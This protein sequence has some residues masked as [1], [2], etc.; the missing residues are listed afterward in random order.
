MTT[1]LPKN[2]KFQ[3]KIEAAAAKSYRSNIS[4]QASTGGYGLGDTITINIPTRS[5]LVMASSENYLKFDH[6]ITNTSGSASSYRLDSCGAHGLI[7]RLKLYHGSNLLEDIDQYGL[8]AKM[9]Y[10]LQMSTDATYGKY[11]ILSGTRNDLVVTTPASI[12][13]VNYLSATQTN[14]GEL[15]ASNL[16]TTVTSTTRNYCLNLISL[17]GSLLQNNY[18]PLFACTSAPLR[19]EITLIDS[20]TKGINCTS[21]I[22]TMR[23]DNVEFCAN[24]I[25][26]GDEAMSMVYESLNGNPLQFYCNQFRNFNTSYLAGASAYTI[27]FPI[28]AKYSSLKSILVTQRDRNT[29]ASTYFPFS[30]VAAGITD[31]S[32]K[33]GTLIMPPK[34]P[35]KLPEMFAEVLKT[36]SS[37]SDANHQPSIDLNSYTLNQSPTLAIATDPNYNAG[38]SGSFYIGLDL[39]NYSNASK[40]TLFAGYNTNTD[41]IYCQINVGIPPVAGTIRYDAFALYDAIYVFRDG[42]AYTTS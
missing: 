40:D 29:G 39:E 42:V 9:L 35:S 18:F 32:F 25:D 36:I 1:L 3:D 7:S 13:S 15:I 31:Y 28:P 22:G 5:N 16:A 10:D 37:L 11:N 19:L 6:T 30:T 27:N 14:S 23:L 38:Q 8:F 2:L 17:V 24:M 20:L 33:I 4:P 21:S 26:L 34:N 12:T 41:D